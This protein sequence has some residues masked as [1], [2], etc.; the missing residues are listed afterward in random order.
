MTAK[1]IDGTAIGNEIK[2]EVKAEV[3]GLRSRDIV[4]GLAAVLVGENPASQIYVQSKVKTCQA[5]G[6]Y[7]EKIDLPAS[8]S[9]QELIARIHALNSREE[10]DGILVQAPLPD[11]IDRLAIFSSID[12]EKDVDGFHPE[13]IGKLC[14]GVDSLQPCTPAGIIEMLRRTGVEIAGRRAVVVGRSDIVGKPMLLLLMHRHATVTVC[15]SK[16][17]NLPEVCRQADILVA[18]MGKPG[19]ITGE[20]VKPGAVVVDV[21]INRLSDRPRILQAFGNDAKRLE[22]LEKKGYTLIGDVEPLSV[23]AV[24]SAMTPVPGGVGPLTIAMLMKNTVKA[25]KRRRGL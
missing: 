12:P 17:R 7:S 23:A 20:Y 13:S 10:I 6:L 22:E 25:A 1:I 11:H 3:D 15:H 24:A 19:M 8:I 14:L 2:A 21:G 9:Q 18:A 16:T 5:L 4:P